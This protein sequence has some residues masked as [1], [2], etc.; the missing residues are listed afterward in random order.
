MTTYKI[1][2]VTRIAK[3]GVAVVLD[4]LV[5]GLDPTIFEPVVLFDTPQGSPIRKQL[6]DSEIATVELLPSRNLRINNNKKNESRKDGSKTQDA[7]HAFYVS[8][9]FKILKSTFSLMIHEFPKI[10]KM[11]GVIRRYHINLVH[12]HSDLRRAKPEIIAAGLAHIPCVT[13]RHGYAEYNAF[14]RLFGRFV[15]KNIYI[16][17][18]VAE[19]HIS[20]GE[21]RSKALII[22]NG[23]DV[24]AY[25]KS[26]DTFAVRKEFAI[27]PDE[28][29]VGHVARL[30]WWKGH[31]F[32]ID[33]MAEVLKQKPNT[34]ALVVGGL[35][36]LNYSTS[37]R[38]LDMLKRKA[39][40][41]GLEKKIIFTGHR[42]DVPRLVSAMDVVVHA[43]STPEPFGL[44]IIE[45]MAA[46]KPVV[47]T[48]AGGVLDIIEDGLNGSLV[49]CKNSHAM[50]IAILQILSDNNKANQ[51]GM[52]ARE[53][54]KERFT[55]THQ[56]SAVEKLYQSI[57]GD[58]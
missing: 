53:F 17:K 51:L 50:A 11:L 21:P 38:Y 28:A 42:A 5:R 46:G 8:Q 20:R 34:T 56:L 43:S 57:L 40:A 14:D 45:A 6:V 10:K 41:L 13:H 25:R 12:T 3:G 29:V 26:G 18:D 52:A 49:P 35:A 19:H 1:L 15:S 37:V 2:H 7:H 22:H 44:T 32:F 24:S 27:G 36:E 33:A 47:A 23:V 39:M 31:E 48:K 58:Y 4:H 16:S 55:I 30:D 9:A 54:I